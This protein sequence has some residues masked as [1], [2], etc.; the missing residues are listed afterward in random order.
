MGKRR[1][2]QIDEDK[3]ITPEM[4]EQFREWMIERE[5]ADATINSYL[6]AI[7]QYSEKYSCISRENALIWKQELIRK[8][9]SA[10][11]VNLRIAAYNSF[12]DMLGFERE[13]I[14]TIKL[15]SANAVSNVI[16]Q[17]DY[18]RLCDALYRDNTR[19]YWNIRLLAVTGARVSEY[20][21]LR[22]ADLDRGYAEMWTKGKMRRIYIPRSFIE[23]AASHYSNLASDDFL[24]TNRFGKPITTRGVSQELKIFSKRYGIPKE[25]MHPHSFRHLF[26]I[27]FL[28]HNQNL[29]LLS[30]VM[31][32]SS[33][34]TT[35]IYTRMTK[36]QQIEAVNETVD[37]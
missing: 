35:A 34:S 20:I 3:A 30:D 1:N 9:R 16:S 36:E 19:W 6:T 4:I 14:R 29:S 26:A 21:R 11:T 10:K 27:N 17:E 28:R 24:V 23:E 8:G 22:K 15:H 37:W 31:G 33:V 13:K 2:G 25:V 7:Q 32:H 5:R 12:C 18:K